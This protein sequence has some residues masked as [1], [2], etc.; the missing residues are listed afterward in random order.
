[1][2]LRG[3]RVVLGILSIAIASLFLTLIEITKVVEFKNIVVEISVL[4]LL[5]LIIAEG[6][7]LLSILL[8]ELISKYILWRN[9]IRLSKTQRNKK[10]KEKEREE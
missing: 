8:A 4:G 2:K 7:Y 3:M 9:T 6:V 5:L 1:M 10:S